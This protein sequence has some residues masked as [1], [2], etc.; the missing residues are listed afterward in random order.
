MNVRGILYLYSSYIGEKYLEI[1]T[2]DTKMY[3]YYTKKREDL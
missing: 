1:V 3:L 2:I